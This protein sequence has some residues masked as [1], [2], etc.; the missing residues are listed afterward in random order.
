MNRKSGITLV[1]IM[2]YVL[3]FFAFSTLAISLSSNMNMN[4]LSKK[5]EIIVNEGYDKL[6]YNLINSAKNSNSVDIIADSVV[7]GNNDEYSFDFDKKVILKNDTVLIKNV[8]DFKII[9]SSDFVSEEK[10]A[11]FDSNIQNISFSVTL[12]KYNVD[13]NENIFVT[14]GE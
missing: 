3:L 11:N 5:G 14:L 7:F 1:S 2:I 9:N 8:E 10:I 13:K 4:S 6:S 12:K